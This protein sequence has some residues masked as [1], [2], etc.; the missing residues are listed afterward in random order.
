MG[1]YKSLLQIIKNNRFNIGDDET[2]VMVIPTGELMKDLDNCAKRG[3]L[4]KDVVSSIGQNLEKQSFKYGDIGLVYQ[5][6][7]MEVIDEILSS[8]IVLYPQVKWERDVAVEQL[9]SL[10]IELG[11]DI[12]SVKEQIRTKAIREFAK[13]VNEKM[14]YCKEPRGSSQNMIYPWDIDQ[15]AEEM[16][17]GTDVQILNEREYICYETGQVMTKNKWSDYYKS[18]GVIDKFVYKD[19]D[20]WWYD[21]RK[22]GV[23]E[24]KDP[25]LDF[26]ND[27]PNVY[28]GQVVK[29]LFRSGSIP[30]GAN[31]TIQSIENGRICI[32]VGGYALTKD[33]FRRTF[34]PRTLQIN[35]YGTV[36]VTTCFDTVEKAQENGFSFAFTDSSRKLDIYTNGKEY[37]TIAEP[38]N[39]C[40]TS[41]GNPHRFPL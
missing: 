7:A 35:E 2:V 12:R 26:I 17:S 23:L 30:R 28:P 14:D 20:E 4:S 21:M 40:W 16:I 8:T 31:C 6:T 15:I 39:P 9:R 5:K 41:P 27:M 13:C 22:S 24:L 37:A 10:G 32:D 36:V 11:E 25:S 29:A 33:E 18:S 19:F 34:G 1:I 38:D 3:K